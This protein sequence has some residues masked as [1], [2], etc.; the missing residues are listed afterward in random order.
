M[1]KF[2]KNQDVSINYE[3]QNHAGQLISAKRAGKPS[4]SLRVGEHAIS[5]HL[6]NVVVEEILD[7]GMC[8]RIAYDAPDVVHGFKTGKMHR[9][10]KVRAWYNVRPMPLNI[11][12]SFT[13]N[14]DIKLRYTNIDVGI[15]IYKHL[16]DS[17]G[18]NFDPP[19]QREYVWTDKDR[20]RLLDSIFMG[21][22]IGRFVARV[23]DDLEYL[24]TG[25][26][27]EII[28]GKQRLLTILDF[29]ENRF[30]YRGFY[31]NGLSQQDK[32]TFLEHNVAWAEVHDIDKEATLRLFL[33][34]NRGGHSVSDEVINRAETL[35]KAIRQK[36]ETATEKTAN[37]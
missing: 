27:Y 29:Y 15:L 26:Y 36:K 22:D 13:C 17:S 37:Q 28:D 3:E 10:S 19:Y 1:E 11:Q 12:S 18:I 5:G 7:D 16:C 30:P 21:A 32:R 25:L 2:K 4:Y 24:E 6:E 33:L 35:L 23:V 34:L 31:F 8:Y 9:E 14:T 20:E